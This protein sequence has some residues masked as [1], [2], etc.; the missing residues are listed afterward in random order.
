[1][2]TILSNVCFSF[3]LVIYHGS[4]IILECFP[5]KQPEPY[6]ISSLFMISGL[7]LYCL[8]FYLILLYFKDLANEPL[9]EESKD[10]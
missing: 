10:I 5:D 2:T 3:S 7:S 8:E 6:V 9:E 1:M 4:E